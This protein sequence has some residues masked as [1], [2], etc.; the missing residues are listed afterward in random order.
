MKKISLC[1]KIT[2]G[3]GACTVATPLVLTATS[4]STNHINVKYISFDDF[5]EDA[6]AGS[7]NFDEGHFSYDKLLLGSRKFFN[8]NYFLFVG[9]NVFD[10]TCI[11]FS[12][13][14]DPTIRNTEQ[15]FTQYL[16]SSYWNID[17]TARS[18]NQDIIDT[19]FGFATFVDDF[20]FKFYDKKGHE[21]FLAKKEEEYH[22]LV[23]P[24]DK[25]DEVTIEQ[26]KKF[27]R[28]QKQYEW[29]DKSV[30]VGDYIREDESAKSYREFCKRGLSF[31]PT[32]EGGRTKSFDVSDGNT[33]SLML[34]Y[35]GGKLKDV[36]DLPQKSYDGLLQ[37]DDNDPA[38]LYGAINKYF[39]LEEP[40]EP[41]PE[42]ETI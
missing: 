16:S 13:A 34:V 15:W 4:C 9:S 21:I 18:E 10:S 36:L 35:K 22:V 19:N 26:T 37:P 40:E 33:T 32:V 1:K 38:T 27:N 11:F 7:I 6:K 2:L 3:L 5:A 42:P 25:W 29:D 20:D 31:F 23:S 8:G 14:K 17:V 28:D 39:P 30:E 12:G 41:E 24:F